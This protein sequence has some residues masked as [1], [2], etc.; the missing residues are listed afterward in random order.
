[1][2]KIIKSWEEVEREVSVVEYYFKVYV[3]IYAVEYMFNDAKMYCILFCCVCLT[4]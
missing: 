1:M 4:L 3:F 2:I